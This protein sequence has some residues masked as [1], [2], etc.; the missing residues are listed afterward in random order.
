MARRGTKRLS[1]AAQRLTLWLL[2]AVVCYTGFVYGRW[3]LREYRCDKL[4]E[5]IA[6]KYGVDKLLVKAVIRQ[7]S[8]FDPFAYSSAGAIGLMQVTEAT[9]QDWANATGHSDFNRDSLWDA[10]VNVEAGTWYL[11]RALQRW[12][13]K[14][15]VER[16]PFA[17]AE[18]N[19]GYG[20]VLKWLPNGRDTTAADFVGAITN[21]GV[22]HYIERITGYYEDYKASGGL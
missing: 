17:L 21:P 4:V 16:I 12:S 13:D 10:R 18:Y 14:P 20:N 7:E 2:I 22:R 3:R 5:E 15:V 8:G 9:G 6:P 19:P 1:P 11:A